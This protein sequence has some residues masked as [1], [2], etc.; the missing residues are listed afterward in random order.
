MHAG[1]AMNVSIRRARGEFLVLKASDTVFSP[2][3]IGMIA[4]R[5]LDE[6]T[7]YRVDR[8]DVT[9]QE[10]SI[11]DLPDD[12]LLDKLAAMPA[13]VHGWVQQP[14]QWKLRDLH[15][16]A[17]GD[18]TLM[19]A[20][21]WH[22]LRGYPYDPTVLALDF[23]SL[24]L[25]AAAALG[26]AECRWPSSCRVYKPRHGNLNNA[27]ISQKWSAWQKAI[28][29]Y[30]LSKGRLAASHWLRTTLNYPRR[31]VRGI[32]SIVGNSIE[33]NF[34]LPASRWSRGEAYVPTQ[35]PNWGLAD[36]RLESRIISRATWDT[37][38]DGDDGQ[39]APAL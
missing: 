34:V 5:D 13:T 30:L 15:T 16:N 7:M 28:D 4:R 3:V 1:E 27:R 32:R 11:W 19:A 2:E 35:G 21:Y 24:V 38:S 10:D 37:T 26:A 17:C 31:E 6:N 14:L 9:I 12:I 20:S 18:F 29:R 25:H 22:R 36:K 8:H 33:R 39:P 23:D